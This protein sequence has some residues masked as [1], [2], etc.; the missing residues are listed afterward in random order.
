MGGG[1]SADPAFGRV[2]DLARTLGRVHERTGWLGLA[3]LVADRA[4]PGDLAYRRRLLLRR[5]CRGRLHPELEPR[6]VVSYERGLARICE[7]LTQSREPGVS[8]LSEE[9]LRA[10]LERGDELWLFHFEG[11]LAHLTW[12]SRGPL[13]SFG[14]RLPLGRNERAN[15]GAV[16]IPSMR[17]RGIARAS[18]SHLQHVI[19]AEGV[20]SLFAVVHGSSRHWHAGMCRM[21]YEPVATVQ[22]IGAAGRLLTRVRPATRSMADLLE[23]RGV[24]CNRWMRVGR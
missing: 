12:V 19:A 13:V 6:R 16:T 2:A 23:E 1:D 20:T 9:S 11:Q 8:A 24:R 17:R 14:L 21:G 15:A 4:L 5:E 7:R 22:A 10:R 3:E 18:F